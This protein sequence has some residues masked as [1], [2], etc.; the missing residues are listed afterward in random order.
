MKYLPK[1]LHCLKFEYIKLK[2][3]AYVVMFDIYKKKHK[4]HQSTFIIKRLPHFGKLYQHIQKFF[5]TH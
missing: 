5:L 3:Q 4:I 1:I 2:H